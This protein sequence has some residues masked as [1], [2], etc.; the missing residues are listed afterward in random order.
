M[1]LHDV[2]LG[3]VVLRSVLP[4]F[5]MVPDVQVLPLSDFGIEKGVV[6]PVLEFIISLGQLT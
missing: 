6:V 4:N 5:D 3:D 2:N 1:L